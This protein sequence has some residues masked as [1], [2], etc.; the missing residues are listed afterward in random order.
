MISLQVLIYV[1]FSVK[2]FLYRFQLYDFFCNIYV[3][4]NFTVMLK[5]DSWSIVVFG[6][7]KLSFDEVSIIVSLS[8]VF[9]TVILLSTE[10][11]VRLLE[12]IKL[13]KTEWR[14]FYL[15][16][17]FST[18]SWVSLTR[19]SIVTFFFLLFLNKDICIKLEVI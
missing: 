8:D 9:R 17:M 2:G 13:V 7:P 18:C 6:L 14:S 4:N 11:G 12:E 3:S 5:V 1:K 16:W 10:T 15:L 19:S